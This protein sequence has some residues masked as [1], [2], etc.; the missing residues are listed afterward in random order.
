MT[1][2]MT[3][4]IRPVHLPLERLE[5]CRGCGSARALRVCSRCG[6]VGIVPHTFVINFAKIT[7]RLLTALRDA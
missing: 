7:D 6:E 1:G 3:S 5:K 2:N 4:V